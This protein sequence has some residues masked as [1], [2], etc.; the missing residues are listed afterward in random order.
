MKRLSLT[1]LMPFVIL[2]SGCPSPGGGGP[3]PAPDPGTGGVVEQKSD[4]FVLQ[5]G[6]SGG[7]A[8]TTNDSAY[9]GPSGYTLWALPLPGQPTFAQRDV[10][11]KKTS[12]N[13]YA[14]YGIVFCQYDTG[15]PSLGETMLVVMIN[16]Q[17]QYSV[18]EATGSVYTPY[19]SPTWIQSQYLT[20]GY[21]GP[22]NVKVTQDAVSQFHLSLNG[23][24][25]MTF[26][27]GR[28]PLHSGGGDGYLVVISPQDSFPGTP[29][30]VSYMDN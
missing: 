27:D 12:G 8:F 17:K 11:L 5:T 6:G 7:Y 24:E 19:T 1:I 29:V 28:T 18:G 23:N 9:W 21:G 25:V 2:L 3:G 15:N 30:T 22:N 10:T 13:T 26:R 4:L 16:A 14:G 20:Y